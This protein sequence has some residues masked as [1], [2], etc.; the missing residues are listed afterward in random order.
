MC[1]CKNNNQ[2]CCCSKGESSCQSQSCG[3]QESGS[4]CGSQS[5]CNCPCH[6]QNKCNCPCHSESSCGGG[7]CCSGQNSCSCNQCTKQKDFSHKLFELA[8][9]A[10]M[11]LLKDKIKQQILSSGGEHLDELAKIVA[12]ANKE[13][14]KHKLS[15]KR[16]CEEHKE[17]IKDFFNK[18][19]E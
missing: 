13:R 18:G 14:W 9:E 12:E 6:N 1:H 8:D 7:S 10:W 16:A 5:A 3:S 15:G 2:S 11:E 4:G 19:K 17:K